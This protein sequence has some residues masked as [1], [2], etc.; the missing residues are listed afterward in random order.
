MNLSLS[1]FIDFYKIREEKFKQLLA[2]KLDVN[3]D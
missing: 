2:N 1:N 3:L